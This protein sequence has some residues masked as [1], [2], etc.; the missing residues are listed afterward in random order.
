MRNTALLFLVVASLLAVPAFAADDDN[1][2][3]P[4]SKDV[5]LLNDASEVLESLTSAPDNGI[6]LDLLNKAECVMVFPHVTKAAFIVG[7]KFGRGVV[8]C[9]NQS[10]RFGAPAFMSVG[11][12]SIGWQ[13]GGQRT[14]FVLLV[15]NKE[16]M[17]HLLEDKFSI[18][19]E[20]SAAIG[21]VGRTGTA[22]TDAQLNAQI[23]SWSRS[24]GLFAGASL[25]GAVIQAS[26]DANE[27]MYGRPT[28]VREIVNGNR[29]VPEAGRSFVSLVDQVANRPFEQ[30]EER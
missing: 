7:G 21:P 4:T 20:V 18:G 29:A 8:V 26:E 15:M 5:K 22:A 12:P 25:E 30:A 28:R 1:A 2:A 23:L 13:W 6:P 10:D 14:A 16:G 27:R 24:K 3:A 9:R 11:G 17:E 19:G